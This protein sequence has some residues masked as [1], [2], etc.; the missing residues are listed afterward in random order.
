MVRPLLTLLLALLLGGC[1]LWALDRQVKMAQR[2]MVLIP[3]QLQA[4]AA[5]PALV[6]LYAEGNLLAYRSVRPGGFFYFSMAAGDYSLLAFEDRNGNLRLDPDEPRHWQARAR[7]APLQLQPSEEQRSAL[8]QLNVLLPQAADDTPLPELDLG[9]ERLYRD[10]P[11]V[12]HNYL[13]VV[14]FDDPRFSAQRT[15]Q[16]AWQPLDFLSEVGYGL[17]VLE[18]WSPDKEPIVL[19]HGINDS[20]RVWHELAAGIDR[21]RYQLLLFHYPSGMP[22]NNSAYLLSEALRD[23]QLRYAPKR[24]HL[25][26]HSMGGLLARR[27]TQLLHPGNA[28]EQ[29][30]LLV[31]LATPWSGHPSAA[32]GAARVP[33]DVPV[34]RDMAP[35][36]AFLQQLFAT[37]L[38][39]H[40]RQWQLVA[41]AGNSR[42]IAEPNDG[43]VPLASQLL[44]AAQDEAERLYLVEENHTGIMRSARSQALLR[45][46]LASLPEEGCASGQ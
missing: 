21:T 34:W 16:G 31:T 23:L 38:P 33:L 4:T 7:T 3:G 27:A 9:L 28:D 35:G 5:Q 25:F 40:V 42:M 19:L 20:P 1:Q 10:L 13:R 8:G 43:S 26:A 24:L 45:R 18:P 17:Y 14:D 29:L 44:P 11:K 22:L 46:A 2:S 32:T 12:R 36:S 37:P 6:A 39:A 41:Y 15:A 30:C